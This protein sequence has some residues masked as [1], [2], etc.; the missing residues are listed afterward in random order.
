MKTSAAE[1]HGYECPRCGKRLAQD[2]KKRGFVRH[3]ERMDDGTIC[4]D[5]PTHERD[6]Q[7]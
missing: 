6:P 5:G 3:V 1:G 2:R 4:P 7:E